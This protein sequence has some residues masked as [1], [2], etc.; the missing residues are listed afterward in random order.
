MKYIKTYKMFEGINGRSDYKEGD[1][2]LI[3]YEITKDDPILTPV[4]IVKIFTKNSYLVSHKNVDGSNLKNF[5]DLTIKF[6]QIISPYKT[7]DE[8]MT[9]LYVTQNPRINP[10]VSGMIPGG[11][12]RPTNDITQLSAN[13]SPSN[14][15]AI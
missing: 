5:P 15:I 2:V 11:N 3:R 8:P 6:S 7:L 4:K 1:I 10:D 9:D 13:Q 14:D 12:S